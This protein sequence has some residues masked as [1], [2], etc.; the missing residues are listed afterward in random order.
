MP[1]PKRRGVHR[2]ALS[3]YA[4]QSMGE[5]P[6]KPPRRLDSKQLRRRMPDAIRAMRPEYTRH[7]NEHFPSSLFSCS[8]LPRRPRPPCSL[9]HENLHYI[10]RSVCQ[11]THSQSC[12]NGFIPLI[13]IRLSGCTSVNCQLLRPSTSWPFCPSHAA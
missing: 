7:R 2:F 5:R 10:C 8:I 11:D 3:A 12:R 1:T 6:L 13:D 4:A 9:R